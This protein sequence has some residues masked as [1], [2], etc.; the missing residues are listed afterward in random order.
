MN[1]GGLDKYGFKLG[2]KRSLAAKLYESGA[3]Q[4]EMKAATGTTQY[5]MLKD[6]ARRGHR[7]IT[8]GDRFW[9]VHSSA[10]APRSTAAV[11]LAPGS[12]SQSW[13]KEKSVKQKRPSS[14]V[15]RGSVRPTILSIVGWHGSEPPEQVV[16]RKSKDIELVGRTLWLLQS[17]KASVQQIHNFS[18]LHSYPMILFLEGDATPTCTADAAQQMSKDGV[19]WQAFPNGL[20]K[21]TGKLPSTGLVVG[22]LSPASEEIADL[23]NYVEY[24]SLQPLKFQ[25]GASTACV[26]PSP[27]GPMKGMKSRLRKV[28]AVGR[29]FP[30]YAVFLR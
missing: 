30:P 4:A 11:S 12:R 5:N 21:V 23:W 7:I 24:P 25:L 1:G 2:S 29:L 19:T 28:V 9:L 17:W 10:S 16:A 8:K 3:T 6:A 15:A 13:T 26:V 27:T 20:G 18:V 22:E 14:Q